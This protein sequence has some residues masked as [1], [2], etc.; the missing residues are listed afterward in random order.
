MSLTHLHVHSEYSQLDGL[1]T[2]QEICERCV[3]L[4]HEHVTLSDHGTVAGHLHF[5]KTAHKYGIKP[6][7]AIEAY[8]GL[9]ST[10]FERNE[11]DQAHL[12]IGALNDE[13]LKNLWRL[14]DASAQNFRYVPRVNWEMLD[15]YKEGLFATSACIQGLVPREIENDQYDSLNRYAEIFKENF[16]VELSTYPDPRQEEVNHRLVLAAFERGLPLTVA[17]DAHYASPEQYPIHDAYVAMSTGENIYIDPSQRKMWHPK[18]LYL[19]DED[20][21][22]NALRYL[23][24]DAVNEAVQNTYDLGCRASADLPEVKRHLPVFVPE[25]SPWVQSLPD[26]FDKRNARNLLL[27]LVSRGLEERYET[28]TEEVW[29]RAKKELKVFLEAGLEHY[30]LQSWDFC[31]YCDENNIKRGPGRGSSAGSIVAYALKITDVDPLHYGLIFERF[32]NPGREKGYPDIDTDFP[33]D[34]RNDVKGYLAKRWGEKNVRSIGNVIRL[35]PKAALDK[36][37]RAFDVS[38]KEMEDLKKIVDKV[39]DLEIH[40]ADTVGWR[41]ESD[42]GKTIYV[43][44]EVGDAIQKYLDRLPEPRRKRLEQ[45]LEFVEVVCSRVQNYG[46]HASGVVVSDGPLDEEL[47]VRWIADQKI[48]VTQFP[49]DDIDERQFV[50]Q[51]ILGLRNLDTLEAWEKEM[52]QTIEWS[53]MDKQEWPKEMWK[54]LEDGLTLGVFQIEDGYGRQLCKTFK[55]QSILDLAIIVALNRPGPIRAGTPEPFLKRRLGEEEVT[56]YHPFLEDVLDETYGLFLYQE[57]VI[58]FFNKMGYTLS[59]SDAVRKILGKKKPEALAALY[60]GKDEWR[61]R[62]YMEMTEAAGIDP[63]SA[64]TIWD[65]M[66]GFA[67]YSF[68]KSHAVA[69]AILAFRTLYAKWTGSAKYIISCIRTNSEKAGKYV[70]E[71]R[72]MDISILC[73]EIDRSLDDIA[74][75]DED[76]LFGFRN[77]KHIGPGTAKYLCELRERYDITSPSRLYA[78]LENETKVYEEEKKE[79]AQSG[80][81]FTRR[82]P[83]QRFRSNLIQVL[84]DAGAFEKYEQRNIPLSTRQMWEKELLQVILTDETEQLFKKHTDLLKKCDDYHNTYTAEYVTLPGVVSHIKE[85]VTKKTK[86]PMAIVTIEHQGAEAEFVVFPSDW[87]SYEFLWKERTAGVFKLRTSE[88]GLSF[89]EGIKLT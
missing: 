59:E 17:S 63:V 82:S 26:Q 73:P 88:R 69:Y 27:D 36:T 48:Y 65:K 42:P 76:I 18:S 64:Q 68:N 13:G 83:K 41:E 50:K 25:K 45:W 30:F 79:A 28:V 7:F 31:R 10:G 66:E 16:F 14:V 60:S 3:D 47:P 2:P 89:K 57:Q 52:G 40:G 33:R 74:L 37:Y 78:A 23:P 15:Y 77:I 81:K 38:W 5:A 46:T 11:R 8:H 75:V 6:I 84:E 19:Q 80:K 29:S 51:D 34:T 54:M 24:Q 67:S 9:K 22:R 53:G 86:A 87:Q 70:S 43:M 21:V 20:E 55:P 62:G 56:Y 44:S 35:K 12:L 1:S 39:P 72:R 49:M 4:R 32:Y 85:T 58:N 71:G 61:G